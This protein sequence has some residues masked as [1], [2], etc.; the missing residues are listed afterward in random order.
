M[1]S[2][3]ARTLLTSSGPVRFRRR[4]FAS[5]ADGGSV[6]VFDL[7]AGLERWR[8]TT[9]AADRML[10]E[11]AAEATYSAASEFWAR[12]WGESPSAMLVW[13]ATQR[14]GSGLVAERRRQRKRVFDDGDLPGWERP[15]PAFVGVE[16]DSTFLPCWRRKGESHE[17]YVGIAYSGK[18]ERHGRRRL[19]G[20]ARC[21]G[22]RGS[23]RFGEDLF[24]TAQRAHNVTEAACGVYLSDG[25]SSLRSVQEDHFPRLVRQLDW[26][27]AKRR[28]IE[29]YGREGAGRSSEL[30][31]L[32]VAGEREAAMR[33]VRA[34]AGRLRRRSEELRELAGYLEGP[35][36]D[37]YGVRRLL[38]AG[39]ELPEHLEGSGGV[40][41]EEGVLVGQRMK[42]RGMSWTGRGAENLLAVRQD[43][44][45]RRQASRPRVT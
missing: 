12:A 39:F 1:K 27:H 29:A 10:A 5:E 36:R 26:A 32:L 24:V 6:L 16:A 41:R 23:R 33:E 13:R 30:V 8:R 25:A 35:G 31:G 21:F 45:D 44:L 3:E 11:T 19:A 34:D 40:E 7:R 4:R 42:R 18:A 37:L 38:E 28:V 17:V 9:A 43:L 2:V 14:V 15:A 20:K 22:L